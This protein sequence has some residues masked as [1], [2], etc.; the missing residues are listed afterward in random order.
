VTKND[1][2]EFAV[3]DV[4]LLDLADPVPVASPEQEPVGGEPSSQTV[5][6]GDDKPRFDGIIG[7]VREFFLGDSEDTPKVRLGWSALVE[8][9]GVL[10]L[11]AAVVIT[12]M[13][14]H[15]SAVMKRSE[16]LLASTDADKGRTAAAQTLTTE[17]LRAQAYYQKV[18]SYQGFAPKSGVK[19]FEA[20][21]DGTVLLLILDTASGCLRAGVRSGT[22]YVSPAP[23]LSADCK[24]LETQSAGYK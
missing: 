12:M 11:L 24:A 22:D 10:V 2:E 7:S 14:S 8:S 5:V 9:A 15:S 16:S 3:I 20:T 6:V 21:P 19:T 23:V 4:A 17:A 18:G 1:W 13:G